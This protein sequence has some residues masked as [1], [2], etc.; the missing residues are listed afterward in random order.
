MD[1]S[2]LQFAADK[3]LQKLYGPRDRR[4]KK[5]S[6]KSNDQSHKVQSPKSKVT[7]QNKTI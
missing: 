1:Y 2:L 6:P 5:A 7:S 3:K 4:A